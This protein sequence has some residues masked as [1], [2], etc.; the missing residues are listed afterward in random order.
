MINRHAVN[1]ARYH[2]GELVLYRCVLP[3]TANFHTAPMTLVDARKQ[4]PDGA[5]LALSCLRLLPLARVLLYLAPSASASSSLQAW[6]TALAAARQPGSDYRHAM[7]AVMLQRVELECSTPSA[8][9][10]QLST[11]VEAALTAVNHPVAL[12]VLAAMLARAKRREGGFVPTGMQTSRLSQLLATVL[13]A[14]GDGAT[15]VHDELLSSSVLTVADL[16]PGSGAPCA[17]KYTA[18][19]LAADDDSVSR[20]MVTRPNRPLLELD[21]WRH[22]QTCSFNRAVTSDLLARFLAKVAASPAPAASSSS[23]SSSPTPAATATTHASYLAKVCSALKSTLIDPSAPLSQRLTLVAASHGQLLD[24]L[25]SLAD[26]WELDKEAATLAAK[27]G[28]TKTIVL[29]LHVLGR[30]SPSLQLHAFRALAALLTTRC[31][32]AM[33]DLVEYG[34]SSGLKEVCM[35]AAREGAN[36]PVSFNAFARLLPPALAGLGLSEA[37]SHAKHYGVDGLRQTTP[38]VWRLLLAGLRVCGPMHPQSAVLAV[39]ALEAMLDI[40]RVAG[41][42]GHDERIEVMEALGRA[43]VAP[44]PSIAIAVAVKAVPA[45]AAVV[46]AARS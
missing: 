43:S 5:I 11:Q 12:G 24:A 19:V 31:T 39:D 18:P 32:R 4:V 36:N 3:R 23:A 25:R 26:S 38:S 2:F 7:V 41:T 44:S 27:Q 37:S 33:L 21:A 34:T 40:S 9:L 22:F 46:V 16:L 15:K 6:L 35:A 20:A 42:L 28:V 10:P 13:A 30:S 1:I 17:T 8:R 45:H 29:A 14:G